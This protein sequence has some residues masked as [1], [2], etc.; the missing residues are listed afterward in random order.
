MKNK[1]IKS[2]L[3]YSTST[4]FARIFG[5]LRSVIVARFLGPRLYGIWNALSIILEYNRYSSLGVLNAMNR[6]VPFFRG[7]GD[8]AKVGQ[9]RRTGFSMACIPSFVVGLVL[10]LISI[11]MQDRAEIEWIMALRA[12][13]FIVFARQLYEFFTLLLRSDNRFLDLSKIQILFSVADLILICVLVIRYGFYGFLWA[14]ALSY[15]WIIAYIFLRERR[16]YNLKFCFNKKILVSLMKLGILMTVIG[17]IINLRTTIDRLMIIKF[18]GVTHLG[19]FGISYVLFQFI[20]LIPSALSQI[21]YPRLVEKYGSS[22]KDTGALRKYVEISTLTLTHLMPILIG[23]IFILLPLGVRLILP[24]YVYGIQAAQITILG[25]FFFSAGIMAANFLITTNRL[26]WYLA[27][28]FVAA[29]INLIMDYVLLKNG[30]GIAGV[31]FGGM[32]FTS[33]VY[34]TCILALVTFHYLGTRIKTFFYIA[35][36]YFPFFYCVTILLM[37][38]YLELNIPSQMIIFCV[39]CIPLLWKLEK[40]T[41]AVSLVFGSIRQGLKR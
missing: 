24:Q 17:V 7:K 21:M 27:F 6:E 25:L 22:N 41:K 28:A 13:A 19:Y 26:Y 39:L 16:T 35:R 38:N 37:L 10:V 40:D 20:F 33:F 30:F 12:I 1:I 11:F 14:M 29:V 2:T 3:F 32:L 23:P 9:I 36:V 15:A 18:L 34:T 31:A 4:F 8:H 5:L